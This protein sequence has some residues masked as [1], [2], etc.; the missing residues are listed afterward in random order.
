MEKQSDISN[1]WKANGV[2]H[3]NGPN[4]LMPLKEGRWVGGTHY[5][6]LKETEES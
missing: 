2:F 1:A 3:G 5:S 6:R 4:K